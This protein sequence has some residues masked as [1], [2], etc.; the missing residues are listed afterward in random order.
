[1]IFSCCDERRLT[2][3][4]R[5]GS[6]NA[7]AFLE[8]RDHEEPSP[9]LR[10]RTLFVRL[11]RPGATLGP[12]NVRITGGERIRTVAVEWVASADALPAG[13]NPALVAGIDDLARTLVVRTRFAGDFSRAASSSLHSVFIALTCLLA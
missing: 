4:R 12:D 2:V 5:D 1:M 7:I 13:T 6:A 8:V 11:L 9:L 10:Q 3:L